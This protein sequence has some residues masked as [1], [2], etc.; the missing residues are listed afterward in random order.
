MIQNNE[1]AN[2][3]WHGA[4]LSLYEENCILSFVKNN[5]TVKLWSFQPLTI[6][7]Q[8]SLCD[9]RE[10]Y[11][12]DDIFKITQGGKPQSIAAFSDLFR[13]KVLEK[14]GGWW[15]DT[16][17]ICLRDQKDFKNLTDT[18]EIIVGFESANYINGAVLNFVNNDLASKAH[19]IAL[20]IL[21]KKEYNIKW[22]EIG[23]KLI[24]SLIQ[25]LEL[26]RDVLSEENF[27]PIHYRQALSILDPAQ[28]QNINERVKESYVYHCWNEILREHSVDKNVVPPAHSFIY[29]KFYGH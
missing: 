22:G 29:E 9:A 1:V 7:P 14:Y 3:F 12:E 4:P 15:F 19:S 16:D 23:P 17:C 28:T 10:F 13:Y 11:Q 5:F 26:S 21:N 25:D 6:P 2:F 24:T 18:R 8:V 27:Y 20:E